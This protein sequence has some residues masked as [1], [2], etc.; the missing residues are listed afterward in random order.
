LL[1][2][3]AVAGFSVGFSGNVTTSNSN[4]T[5]NYRQVDTVAVTSYG[6]A[7]IQY[8]SVSVTKNSASLNL[9]LVVGAAY[10]AIGVPPTDYLAFYDDMNNWS[11]NNNSLTFTVSDGQGLIT[12]IYKELDEVTAGPNGTLTV[13]QK[14]NLGNLLWTATDS[15]VGSGGLRTLTVKGT[16]LNLGNNNKNSNFSVS[17][18]WI[19]SDTTGVLN[20]TGNPIVTPKTIESTITVTNFPYTSTANQVRLST[21]VGSAEINF[22]VTGTVLHVVAGGNTPSYVSFSG[23]ANVDGK[24]TQVTHIYNISSNSGSFGNNQIAAQITAAFNEKASFTEVQTLFP[25]GAAS[26]EFD[27]VIGAN[28]MPPEMTGTTY[29]ASNTDGN[30]Y[31]GGVATLIPSALCLLFAKLFF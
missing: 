7:G 10:A 8:K 22:D 11:G 25:A 3:S 9:D 31:T 21:I 17:V 4:G 24:V 12:K 2:A 19:I 30:G 15:N 13:V 5:Y 27:P 28:S 26:I 1:F 6:Y 23:V 14:V 20:L 16:P 29:T 18:T